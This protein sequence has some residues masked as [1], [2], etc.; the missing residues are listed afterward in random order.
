MSPRPRRAAHT[1]PAGS[2]AIAHDYLATVGGAE[3]VLLSLSHAFP[4]ATVFTSIYN[5][6]RVTPELAEGLH[7]RASGLN[8]VGFLR[9]N[10]R[11]AF[12]ALAPTFDRM[13]VDADVVVCSSS[14]WAH[15]IRTDGRKVVYCHNVAR[16]LY[17]PDDFFAGGQTSLAPGIGGDAALPAPLGP[18]VR[19]QLQPIPREL[20][21]R[22]S[23]RAGRLRHR[24]HR[25]SAADSIRCRRPARARPRH[26]AR[27]PALGRTAARLQERAAG[28]RGD[29]AAPG[30]APGGRR[31]RAAASGRSR[32]APRTNVSFTGPVTEAQL[33]WLYAQLLRLRVR[34]D[35]RLRP[36]PTR[37]GPLRQ[38]RGPA[39][40]GRLPRL[41]HRRRDRRVLRRARPD[42]IAAAIR[43]LARQSWSATRIRENARSFSEA[44]FV[45]RM[46]D[47][48]D[49]ELV[50]V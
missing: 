8:R 24:G 27:L 3:R 25:R 13:R 43:T 32:R 23:T 29:G 50:Q 19:S 26:R 33:R 42:Q 21:P 22:R 39:P 47:I 28:H 35:R 12:P 49:E 45:Q 48:V 20:L 18:A 2:V 15:G 4:D 7:V 31:Q 36:D 17:Q 11:A 6:E 40:G 10:Y 46:R 16:W 41:H 38:A 37:G 30:H 9:N 44:R 14:G 34:V 5:P 1:R